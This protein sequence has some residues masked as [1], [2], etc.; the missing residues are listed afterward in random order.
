MDRHPYRPAH[1]H[2]I[3][4]HEGHKPITTQVYDAES[5]YLDND[6]VFAVKQSLVGKFEPRK[7]DPQAE[8]QL[9]FDVILARDE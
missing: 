7:G 5:K 2:Y 4:Q 1:I 8:W 9:K 3:V 6:S